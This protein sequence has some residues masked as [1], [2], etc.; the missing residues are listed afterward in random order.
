MGPTTKQ[1]AYAFSRTIPVNGTV[2]V[3]DCEF[4]EFF[5]QEAKIQRKVIVAD[6][7]KIRRLLDKF[8]YLYSNNCAMPLLWRS[9]WAL[10]R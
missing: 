8:N 6:G 1:I 4:T 2:I 5:K 3:P 10:T 7:G 9:C